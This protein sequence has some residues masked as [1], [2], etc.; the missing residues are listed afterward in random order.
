[1]KLDVLS[2]RDVAEAARVPRAHVGQRL[3]LIGAQH[4]LR[5]LHAQHLR[6]RRLPLAVGAAHQAEGAPL[7][8][9][10]L[11]ALVALERRHEFVDVGLAGE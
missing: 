5:D 7:V 9:R 6:V 3:E 8:R 11:P 1:M 4:A 2:R 10:E